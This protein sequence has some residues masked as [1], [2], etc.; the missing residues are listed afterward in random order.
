MIHQGQ[1]PWTQLEQ[2]V[3]RCLTCSDE[4]CVLLHLHWVVD[5]QTDTHVHDGVMHHLHAQS[6]HSTYST[7]LLSHTHQQGKK[8]KQQTLYKQTL[9]L[10][11]VILPVL[12]IEKIKEASLPAL[13]VILLAL[14]IEKKG[15]TIASLSTQQER[16]PQNVTPPAA[17]VNLVHC[18]KGH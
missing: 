10:L 1:S 11:S 2:R 7:S 12:Q 6:Q 15:S 18:T 8:T 13:S 9:I 4:E 3:V 17:V 5:V 14:R 16:C